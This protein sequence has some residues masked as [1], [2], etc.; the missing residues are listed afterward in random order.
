M[1]GAGDESEH[2]EGL[3]ER[4]GPL[5]SPGKVLAIDWGEK[6]I[7]LAISNATQTLAHPLDTLNRRAG[8]RFP[9]KKLKVYLDDHAPVGVV[10]GLPL[11]PD[12][13][14][15]RAAEKARADGAVVHAK[16]GLPIYYLDERF[17]TARAIGAIRELGGNPRTKPGVVDQLAATV[18][19]QSYL[20]RLIA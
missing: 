7:G 15:G 20:D 13:N 19:L 11:K 18:L 3:E 12:G 9:M 8:R 5:P 6:H 2:G 10:M 17:T 4:G 14:E 1:V 16:T